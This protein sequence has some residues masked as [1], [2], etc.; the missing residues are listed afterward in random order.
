MD[1]NGSFDHQE[2]VTYQTF[3]SMSWGLDEG[4]GARGLDKFLPQTTYKISLK[5]ASMLFQK[6]AL[7]YRSRASLP[8]RG[9]G[10]RT[11][12]RLILLAGFAGENNLASLLVGYDGYDGKS[13][14]KYLGNAILK[15]L[16]QLTKHATNEV[17]VKHR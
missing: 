13:V 16:L 17:F 8:A 5:F 14:N 1:Y 3:W 11:F 15:S 10:H 2:I 7:K 12:L 9:M 4:T 6:P